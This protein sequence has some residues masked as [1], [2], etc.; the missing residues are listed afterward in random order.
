MQQT[1][2]EAVE[3]KPVRSVFPYHC[4]TTE[5]DI[6]WSMHFLFTLSNAVLASILY[7]SRNGGL[8]TFLLTLALNK[9]GFTMLSATGIA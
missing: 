8:L 3:P 9:F 1:N 4:S 2:D 6:T 7:F 5:F